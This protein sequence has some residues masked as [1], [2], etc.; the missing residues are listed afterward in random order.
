MKIKIQPLLIALTVL[1]TV[2]RAFA[3]ADDA[4]TAMVYQG[5]LSRQTNDVGNYTYDMTFTL[6]S[7]STGGSPV[8]GPVTNTALAVNS[9]G[10]FAASLNFG[11][12]VFNGS[13]NWLEIGVRTNGGGAFTTLTPRQRLGSTP[14]SIFAL[15]AG[16]AVSA[17]TATTAASFTGTVAGDVAGTQGATV[18]ASVG[19]QTAAYV[20]TGASAANAATSANTP[21][22]LVK[23]D[24][25][26]S[27]AAGSVT[28]GGSLYLPYPAI[29]YSGSN[30]VLVEEGSTFVGL[31]AGAAQPPSP[32]YHNVGVGTWAL[33]SDTTGSNNT[34]VGEFAMNSNITGSNNKADGYQALYSNTSGSDNTAI[35]YQ[36]LYFNNAD[37]NT[38][39]GWQALYANTTGH[40]NVANGYV[41]LQYNTTGHYNTANGGGALQLNTTGNYNT[42]NGAG[43]LNDNTNGNYNTAIGFQALAVNTSGSDNTASGLQALFLNTI[44]S[45]NSASGEHALFSNT[46]GSQNAAN[47]YEALYNNTNGFYNTANGVD[48]LFH[49]TSG[50]NNIAVGYLAGYNLTIGNNNIDIGNQ[51]ISGEGN[52]IRVGVQGTQTN[53]YVAGIWGTTIASNGAAVY[54]DSNGHLGTGATTAITTVSLTPTLPSLA[55]GSVPLPIEPETMALAG[56]YA[57]IVCNGGNKLQVVDVSMVSNPQLLGSASTDS[58]AYYVAVAG[59]YAYVLNYNSATLQVFDIDRK[60]TRLN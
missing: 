29:I 28:L 52:T 2:S 27:F 16:T 15:N 34:A 42:A 14:Q 18:V 6:F 50:T 59:R 41:A 56:R 3:A 55:V 40:E 44:G 35:G 23:R 37:Y 36:A 60:S 10:L 4:S 1:A 38:A 25:S 47:G 46:T 51:G 33:H 48:A 24:G 58:G 5:L 32:D 12:S 7:A 26:G 13:T 9:N 43:A 22:T 8:A 30:T 49:N 45:S 11:S 57:Y 17:T 19:G 31:G 21:N 20:A 54:V 39:I 53:T